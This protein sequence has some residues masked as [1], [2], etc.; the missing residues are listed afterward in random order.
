L[1][2]NDT[3]RGIVMTRGIR[4]K[5]LTNRDL[6]NLGLPNALLMGPEA[7]P[8]SLLDD[9]I[10]L[11][12]VLPDEAEPTALIQGVRYELEQT[13]NLLDDALAAVLRR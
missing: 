12:D 5:T 9:A 13:L 8:Q 1:N 11:L 3:K 10:G 7:I 6:D 4:L 2:E